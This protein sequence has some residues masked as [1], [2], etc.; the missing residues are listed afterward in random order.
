MNCYIDNGGLYERKKIKFNLIIL[1]TVPCGM[2]LLFTG[3]NV[4]DPSTEPTQTGAYIQPENSV[5]YYGA[6]GDEKTDDTQAFIKAI[7]ESDSI[8]VSVGQYLI[9]SD[10]TFDVPVEVETGAVLNVSDGVTLIFFSI[11]GCR[12][13]SDF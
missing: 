7:S 10:I 4:S 3:C 6:V 9:Q 12:S 11:F 1:A 5:K 2:I 8:Y 13:M